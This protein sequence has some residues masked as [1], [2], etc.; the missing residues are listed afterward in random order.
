MT[1]PPVLAA[2]SATLALAGLL[3]IAAAIDIRERRLPDL[4][5]AAIFMSGLVATWLLGRD[6]LAALIGAVAGYLAIVAVNALFRRMRGRDGIGMGDA[7]LLGALGAWVAWWGLPFVVLIAAAAGLAV[8]AV[9]RAN[10]GDMLPF[11]P[12]LAG[13][14]LI[15]WLTQTYS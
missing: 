7:K 14:G 1:D 10:R 12:F 13:A 6:L 15:V 11:G 9:R 8:A 3:L 5:N 4:I 2:A